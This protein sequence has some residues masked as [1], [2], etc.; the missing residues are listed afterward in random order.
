MIETVTV[1]IHLDRTLCFVN[2]SL[3]EALSVLTRKTLSPRGSGDKM[4]ALLMK[5]VEKERK[6]LLA[7]SS[8][9]KTSVKSFHTQRGQYDVHFMAP[10]GQFTHFTHAIKNG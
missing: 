9:V 5:H 2:N 8:P 1:Q 7:P 6:R 3:R 4:A 10:T